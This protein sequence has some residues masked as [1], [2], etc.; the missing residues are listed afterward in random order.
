M[1]TMK[2]TCRSDSCNTLQKCLKVSSPRSF[3]ISSRSLSNC[4][5]RAFVEV[6]G[7]LNCNCMT[8]LK[9]IRLSECN[10][11]DDIFDDLVGIIENTTELK[12]IDIS[13]NQITDKS[14]YR[15]LLALSK[16]TSSLEYLN[17][18]DN[19]KISATGVTYISEMMELSSSLS[20]LNLCGINLASSRNHFCE[21][22]GL[23]K[24]LKT[25]LLENCGFSAKDLKY[26]LNM[27]Q[28]NESKCDLKE[29][30]F[31]FNNFTSREAAECFE[32]LL[33]DKTF[34]SI[35]RLNLSGV[36]SLSLPSFARTVIGI[37]GS[38]SEPILS[39]STNKSRSSCPKR[40]SFM[41]KYQKSDK[42]KP[43]SDTNYFASMVFKSL[44]TNTTLKSLL[45]QNN[46]LSLDVAGVLTKTLARN[47]TLKEL[48]LSMNN[49]N[50]KSIES[51]LKAILDNKLTNL[52][53]VNFRC[54]LAEKTERVL[55]FCKSLSERGITVHL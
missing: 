4:E 16:S 18:E 8:Q 3:D 53:Q 34:D 24:S 2:T 38:T 39:K 21:G 37:S 7:A 15:L 35:E 41:P 29:V 19:S 32:P 14:I 12:R 45:L 54:N 50:T 43:T 22:L 48:D 44:E 51:F 11:N 17:L 49:F 10:I 47:L 36:A 42:A 30:S 5:R 27:L 20:Y 1:Q 25:L 13:S 33:C 9:A 23:C 31:A 52:K 26:L 55:E 40:F 46:N 6:N 28:E